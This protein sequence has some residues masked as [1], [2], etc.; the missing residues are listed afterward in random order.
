MADLIIV[1][2]N[3]LV[4]ALLSPRGNPSLILRM[5]LSESLRIVLDRRVYQEYRVV[6][7]RPKFSF[8]EVRREALLTF[9]KNEG[10]WI[11]PKPVFL[12]ISDPSDLPFIELSL[13]THAPVITGNTKH[14]PCDLNILTPAEF[15]A[16]YREK[17]LLTQQ[18]QQQ[19]HTRK[20]G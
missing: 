5:I 13:H 9:L 2:T 4:S 12:E 11:T 14:Y 3:V 17:N 19:D 20:T 6:L 16:L 15:I 8:D 1:D 10:F 18:Q 7:S